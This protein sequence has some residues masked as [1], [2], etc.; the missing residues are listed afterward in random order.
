MATAVVNAPFVSGGRTPSDVAALSPPVSSILAAE[1]SKTTPTDRDS[2]PID[3]IDALLR[4]RAKDYGANEAIV[5]YPSRGT[6]Y[7]YYT[8]KQVRKTSA[9]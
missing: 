2:A 4:H 6:D 1:P 5:A 9:S 7:V 3:T 8:P